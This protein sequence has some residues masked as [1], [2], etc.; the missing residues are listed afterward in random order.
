[1]IQMAREK[2]QARSGQCL[3][4]T[5]RP[6]PQAVLRPRSPID[7]ILPYEK[8]LQILADLGVDQT[9]EEPF[10]WEFSQ[11]D[12]E[13][14]F[15]TI[16]IDRLGA[17]VIV[18]GYNFSF[19]KGR[20]GQLETL[21]EFCQRAKIELIVVEPHCI[22]GQVV[23]SSQIRQLLLAGEVEKASV[24]LGRLFSYQ[25]LV[26]KGE[27]RGKKLGFPTANLKIENQLTLPFGV[28]ATWARVAGQ[29][30]RSVTN[31]GV[32]P[33]FQEAGFAASV[34]V[35]TH[36]M[37]GSPDLYGLPLEVQFVSRIRSEKKFT[38]V[39]ALREQIAKDLT[40]ALGR[41]T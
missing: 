31:V 9:L 35:E 39:E 2:A 16:M 13:T 11:T 14:F 24:F 19:G 6:H 30:Y 21:R 36:L 12:A 17:E 34:L 32:R 23:S 18:V 26:L 4:Y 3:V 25:G 5:F 33:T 22:Q 27:G 37:E 7:L 10:T 20:Q 41:L 8:K 38:G 40:E 1:M 15:Q 29:T 28:Y